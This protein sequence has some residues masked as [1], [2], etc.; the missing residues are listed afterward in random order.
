MI[1]HLLIGVAVAWGVVAALAGFQWAVRYLD[2]LTNEFVTLGFGITCL[3]GALG[4]LL[5]LAS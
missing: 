3:G 2:S 5:W 4:I 1:E